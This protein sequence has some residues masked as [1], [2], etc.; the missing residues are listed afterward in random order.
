MRKRLLKDAFG[1]GFILWF[2]GFG[3]GILLFAIIPQAFIGWIIMPIGVAI[4]LWILTRKINSQSLR[5]FSYVAVIW[6]VIAVAG[7]YYFIVKAFNPA[8]GYYK[9]DVY[10]YYFLIFT[11]PIM[12]GLKK[13][14]TNNIRMFHL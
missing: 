3:L 1:W 4:T 6:T 9:L 5:Y 11:L 12:V 7:D 14:K 8:D 2:I 10:L 13:S